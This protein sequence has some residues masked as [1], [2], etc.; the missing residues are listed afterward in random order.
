MDTIVIMHTKE[1]EV[2]NWHLPGFHFVLIESILMLM[3]E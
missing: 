2:L 1:D 3:L